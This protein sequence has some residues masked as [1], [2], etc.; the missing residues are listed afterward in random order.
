MRDRRRGC[1]GHSAARSRP[2]AHRSRGTAGRYRASRRRRRCRARASRCVSTWSSRPKLVVNTI[3]PSTSRAEAR[4]ALARRASR[5]AI[6]RGQRSACRSSARH[7]AARM[8]SSDS[9]RPPPAI[10]P[11]QLQHDAAGARIDRIDDRRRAAAPARARSRPH[12]SARSPRHAGRRQ[13]CR[14]RPHR[15]SARPCRGAAAVPSRTVTAVADVERRLVQPEHARAQPA[16]RSAGPSDDS[17]ITSP[18]STKISSIERDADRLP[19]Q[20]L[21]RHARFVRHR[22]GFDRTARARPCRPRGM[23]VISSPTAMLP[24]STRPAMMRRSSNL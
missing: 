13:A 4:D 11:V 16:R 10:R 1:G 9:T 23:T 15:R 17:E 12:G 3:R 7:A 14:G 24:V 22:P 20:R 21:A 8:R 18:R 2:T 5:F 6:E 19:G